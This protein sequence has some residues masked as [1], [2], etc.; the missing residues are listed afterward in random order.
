VRAAAWL[1]VLF[2]RSTEEF[3][4][5]RSPAKRG[6]SKGRQQTYI[7]QPFETQPLAAPQGEVFFGAAAKKDGLAV[8]SGDIASGL[9]ACFKVELG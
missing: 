9:L 7:G 2:D 3:L 1:P 5:L 8:L 6:V 4:T